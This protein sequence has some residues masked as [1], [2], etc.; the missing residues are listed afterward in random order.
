MPVARELF[1]GGLV[2]RL[3]DGFREREGGG[4]GGGGGVVHEQN[5]DHRFIK[6]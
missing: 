1:A 3:M 2:V 4:W 6:I 5:M